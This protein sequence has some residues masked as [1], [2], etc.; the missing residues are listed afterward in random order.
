MGPRWIVFD[1]ASARHRGSHPVAGEP[2]IKESVLAR[3]RYPMRALRADHQMT[4][5]S[6]YEGTIAECLRTD[7]PI[8]RNDIGGP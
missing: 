3:V 8:A 7:V 4:V 2:V 6:L 5:E 1:S